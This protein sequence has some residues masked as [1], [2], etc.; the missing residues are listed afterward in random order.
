MANTKGPDLQG[1]QNSGCEEKNRW[2]EGGH[3]GQTVQEE[4]SEHNHKS[5]GIS[6]ILKDKRKKNQGVKHS[7]KVIPT[8]ESH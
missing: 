3:A 2:A 6:F 1:G 8:K 5:C 4:E 7:P